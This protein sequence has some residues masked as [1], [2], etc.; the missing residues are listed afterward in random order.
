M[1][2]LYA[3][4]IVAYRFT[5]GE[6]LYTTSNVYMCLAETETEAGAAAYLEA[7]GRWP[8]AD[9]WS[10]HDANAAEVPEGLIKAA[11]KERH[12]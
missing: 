12:G 8:K 2:K 9:G 6:G 7:V 4:A 3:A 1:L 5:K 10:G 11:N